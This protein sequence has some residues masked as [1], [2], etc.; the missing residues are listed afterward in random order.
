MSSLT[1][2]VPSLNEEKNIENTFNRINNVVP[3]YFDDFEVLLFN[4]G[5]TDSTSNIIEKIKEQNKDKVKTIHHSFPCGLGYVY[6]KGLEIA[7]KDYVIMIPGDDQM[8]EQ[9]MI[10]IFECKAKADMVIPYTSNQW[11]RPLLRRVVSTI[12][13]TLL[14]ILFGYKIRYYNGTVLH[15]REIIQSIKI[16]T[17]SFFYQAE[18]LIKL[19]GHGKTFIEVGV[20][21]K[22]REGGKTKAF[23][24]KN[25][26]NVIKDIIKLKFS[27]L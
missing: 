14:N 13:T 24:L 18:A 22:E 7:T 26:Y 1:V 10:N 17:D 4:D 2:I 20:P 5:S 9:A 11:V 8:L 16:T 15:K 25:I 23:S 21:I 6:K 3:K 27:L 12:Y 19:L